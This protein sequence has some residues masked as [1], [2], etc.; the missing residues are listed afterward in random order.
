M[1]TFLITVSL[2]LL[3]SAHSFAADTITFTTKDNKTTYT[4][5]TI[6]DENKHQLTIKTETGEVVTVPI[7]KLPSKLAEECRKSPV[8]GT[9]N[10]GGSTHY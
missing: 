8:H 1:K 2:V 9:D 6:I 3:M 4:N 10:I 5:A 7:S